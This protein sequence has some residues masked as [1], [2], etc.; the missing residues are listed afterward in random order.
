MNLSRIDEILVSRKSRRSWTLE[1]EGFFRELARVHG[2]SF[3]NEVLE[4]EISFPLNLSSSDLLIL[5]YLDSVDLVAVDD[6]LTFLI[7]SKIPRNKCSLG[8]PFLLAFPLDS[9]TLSFTE[10]FI[11][12]NPSENV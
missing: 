1:D 2:I 12:E 6:P 3:V 9:E 8:S 7:L 11:F 4:S 5:E 10:V